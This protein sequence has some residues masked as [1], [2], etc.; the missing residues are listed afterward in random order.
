MK[1]LSL[2]IIHALFFLSCDYGYHDILRE[3]GIISA[4]NLSDYLSNSA[5]VSPGDGSWLAGRD[6]AINNEITLQCITSM[7]PDTLVVS[8]SVSGIE[9][10]QVIWSSTSIDNDTLSIRP[11]AGG[12]W[13]FGS[14][15]L[16]T[17]TCSTLEEVELTI[18]R[19]FN[20]ASSVYYVKASAAGAL[21]GTRDEPM[22]SMQS[23]VDAASGN[24]PGVV[25]VAQG[26]FTHSIANTNMVDM[27]NNVAMYGGYS[28]S[29]WETRDPQAYPTVLR[30]LRT[31]GTGSNGN[32]L[33][34]PY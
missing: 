22:D 17:I 4:D 3:S 2:F 34:N 10:S 5:V 26:E 24:T 19:T 14:G 7:D 31:N 30:D 13:S 20:I 11:P 32:L 25:L 21:T 27:V 8:G 9:N 6:A 1:R 33:T 29:D 16:F 23:A 28:S 15:A 18:S 12:S